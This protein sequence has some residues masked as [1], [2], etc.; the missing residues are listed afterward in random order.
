MVNPV[1]L[2]TFYV[3]YKGV[4]DFEDVYRLIYR[5]YRDR[6]YRYYEKKYKNKPESPWG[7]EHE[8]YLEG[9]KKV[10]SF[11]QYIINIDINVIDSAEIEID[12]RKLFDGRIHIAIY[13]VINRDY[14]DKFDRN[15]FTRW[16]GNM[17][18]TITKLEM[19]LLHWDVLHYKMQ[20]LAEDLKNHLN[21]YADVN[22][23]KW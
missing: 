10:D 1:P 6:K 13:G 19:E 11:Y 9:E 16:I 17:Y 18:Y 20:D 2:E 23:Y 12:G 4:Y 22:Y 8:L 14:S 15:W 7:Y 5:W 21:M 3:R